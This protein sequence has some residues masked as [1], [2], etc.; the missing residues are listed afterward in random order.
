M[1]CMKNDVK[2]EALLGAYLCSDVTPEERTAVEAHLA[3]DSGLMALL[4]EYKE[5][6]RLLERNELHVTPE[7][8]AELKKRVFEKINDLAANAGTL[9]LLSAS[10][11]ND[12]SKEDAR[13]LRK[14]LGAH[15]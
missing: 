6:V 10:L 15:P 8:A 14:Y 5:L 7:M 11:S 12:L 3:Q 4:G 9:P 13:A 2:I 1:N